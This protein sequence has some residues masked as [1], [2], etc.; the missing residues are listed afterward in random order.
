[1]S[2]LDNLENSVKA[3]EAREQRDP[4]ALQRERQARE[5]A[6]EAARLSAPHAAA[7]RDYAPNLLAAARLA[8]HASRTLV[9]MSW[10][11]TTARFEAKSKRLDLRPDVGG[12]IAVFS[13][14]GVERGVEPLDLNGDPAHLAARWLDG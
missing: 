8:G 4:E 10:I 14:N 12:V 5:A 7:L 11:Q 1:M 9:R 13:E 6:Q 2:F 3:M